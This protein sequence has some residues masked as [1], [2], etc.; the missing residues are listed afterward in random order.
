NAASVSM[1]FNAQGH[2]IFYVN[3]SWLNPQYAWLLCNLNNKSTLLAYEPNEVPTESYLQD[4]AQIAL[5]GPN[6]KMG[7]WLNFQNITDTLTLPPSQ[8]TPYSWKIG[9]GLASLSTQ[10][11]LELDTVNP[12]LGAQ[13]FPSANM[14]FNGTGLP[15]TGELKMAL[16]FANN[17]D[18]VKNLHVGLQNMTVHDG[19]FGRAVLNNVNLGPIAWQLYALMNEHLYLK[20]STVNEIGI[21][22]PSTIT[23]DSCVLQLGELASVGQGGSTFTINNS[24]IWNQLI[25]AGNSSMMTLNTCRVT[26]SA[27]STTDPSSHVTVNGGCFFSNPTGCAPNNMVNIATGVPN[28]NPYIPSGFPQNLTPATVTFNGVNMT[29]STGIAELGN[30]EDIRVFPNPTSGILHFLLPQPDLALIEIYSLLGEELLKTKNV[31]LLDISV[32]PAGIY[33]V[34][35]K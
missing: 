32:L 11:Y 31:G 25:T 33:F 7:L 30:A 8:A 28:C 20:N 19:P 2:S 5:H 13:I 3:K 21:A 35:V 27:F 9:R 1:N 15:L 12:G 29:C 18:T 6:T 24:D 4:T 34:K 22:G 17:T 16:I 26:G 14:T 23:A 10:W